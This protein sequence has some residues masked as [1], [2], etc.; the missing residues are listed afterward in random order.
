M[1]FVKKMKELK[2]SVTTSEMLVV[3]SL[4]ELVF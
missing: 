1:I 2:R 3:E 4:K